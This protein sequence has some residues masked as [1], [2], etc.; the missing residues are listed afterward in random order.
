MQYHHYQHLGDVDRPDLRA[1]KMIVPR[2]KRRNRH[3]CGRVPRW[4]EL[5]VFLE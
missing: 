3:S 4:C 2:A 1:N 5:K